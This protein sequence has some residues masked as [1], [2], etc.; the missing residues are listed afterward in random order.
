MMAFAIP[1]FRALILRRSAPE[2]KKSHLMELPMEL[3]KM[4]LSKD[5]FHVTDMV[6]RIPGNHSIV[7]FGHV[8]DDHALTKWLSSQWTALY[9]DELTTFSY[10]Q[11]TWLLTS[12]RSTIPGMV[13]YFKA[14]T[15]PVGPGSG[16]VRD[17]W[18][19]KDAAQNPDQYP[20]YNPD[21]YLNI[22][23]NLDDNPHLD[24][25]SYGK[26]FE[27]IP[28]QAVRDA[29]RHGIW[30]IEGQ[31]FPEWAPNKDGKPWHVIPELPKYK[32]RS[33]LEVKGIEVFC[34]IDWGFSDYGCALWVA[35]MF[36]GSLVV[37]DEL[38]FKGLLPR[39]VAEE[40][41]R[42]N[43]GL[44]VR[45]TVA[46]PAMWA[47]HEGPSIAEHMERAGV[48]MIEGD[49]QR[50]P[51]WVQMHTWLRDTVNDGLGPRPKLRVVGPKCPYLVRTIPTMVVD[52]KDVE[53]IKTKGVED[54]ACFVAGT[55]VLTSTGDV[56]IE[57]MTAGDWVWTRHGLRKVRI[58]AQTG[59]RPVFELVTT[60]PSVVATADH[61]FWTN[62]GWKSLD[63]LRPGDVVY[64][65]SGGGSSSS[66]RK[67]PTT[68]L[69]ETTGSRTFP[70]NEPASTT[71][72]ENSGRRPSAPSLMGG[73]FT[74]ETGTRS[75]T[76][77]VTSKPSPSRSMDAPTGG[78]PAAGSRKK[79]KKR[80]APGAKLQRVWR[81]ISDWARS[82]G[83]TEPLSA[84]CASSVVGSISPEIEAT[85][86]SVATPAS[87]RVDAPPVST[88]KHAPAPGAGSTSSPTSTPTA[89]VAPVDAVVVTGTRPAG[90]QTVYNL[91][92]EGVHEYF[93]NG[94]L[95]SNCD[96]LRYALMSRPS[97]SKFPTQDPVSAQIFRDLFRTQTRSHRLGSEATH[98]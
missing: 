55:S 23:C 10:T 7:Q 19:T 51:G 87:P 37:F 52:D 76:E 59:Q 69:P 27:G 95:V 62:T 39:E 70:R 35:S 3:A 32:G 38:L 42:R 2:L 65:W 91:S 4:G 94:L 48:P 9:I 24:P 11:F 31:A 16:F 49:R 53:D 84:A 50:K 93:A 86:S 61:P 17:L 56:P 20:G 74:T 77:S 1:N 12:L 25:V 45:Y 26:L 29:L 36:D 78:G 6:L 47:E 15:N 46:D 81:S 40:M 68:P 5:A 64:Q 90:T 72:T 14:G 18:I 34:A 60:G 57:H 30:S 43:E 63:Q 88:T 58:A 80:P 79:G 22:H 33:V 82:R 96:T 98:R 8:E 89:A 13:T 66:D 21:D 54:H 75:T 83:R 71:C 44:K 73:T 92:V 67:C 28:S 85:R 97:A 41:R